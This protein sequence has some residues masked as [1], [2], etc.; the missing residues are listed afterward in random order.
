MYTVSNRPNLDWVTWVFLG[1]VALAGIFYTSFELTPSSYG[2]LLA[3]IG[4][5]EEG[6][7][8]GN[9]R[10][11]RSDEWAMTTPF[12]QAAVRNDFHRFNA[13]SFYKED[14]RGQSIPVALPLKD[15]G[16]VFKPQLW[17]FFLTSPAIAYSAFWALMMCGCL[18]GYQ[19][20][21]RQFGADPLLAVAVSL[22]I[23]CCGFSQFWWTTFAPLIA[24]FPWILLIL[25][26]SLRWWHKALLFSWLMPVWGLADLYPGE[27]VDLAFISLV[28]VLA[29]RPALLRQPR[30]IAAV[31]I[32]ALAMLLVIAA[33]YADVIPAMRDSEYPGHRV[34]EPG[35][36]SAAVALS[37]FFPYLAF[38]LSGYVPIIKSNICELGA[39]GSF[40]PVLNLCLVR[41]RDVWN[42]RFVRRALIILMS[43]LA[44]VT[45]WE[46]APAPHWIGRILQWDTAPATR[47]LLA[48][49]LLI[50]FASVLLWSRNLITV[51]PARIRVF[52]LAGPLAAVLLKLGVYHVSLQASTRD[53][54]VFAFLCVAAV[55]A[56]YVPATVGPAVLIAAIA[57]VNVYAFGRF[58][59]LQPA[60]PIFLTPET[61]I[62]HQLR[63][64]QDA[65]P[66]HILINAN[67]P[68]ATLNGLGV[69]AVSH[70]LM[71][72]MPIFFRQYFPTMDAHQFNQVFNRVSHIQVTDDKLPRAVFMDYLA[73]PHQAFEPVLNL[74]Q[75]TIETVSHKDC[76]IQ[77]GGRIERVTDQGDQVMIDGWAPWTGEDKTQELH[78]SSAR[79]LRAGALLTIKRLDVAETLKDYGFARAG[80][81]LTLSS[82]DGKPLHPDE[83]VLVA[84]NTS[85]GLAQLTG[86][87]CR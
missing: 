34:A 55:V 41:Y 32:G 72:P 6:P 64:A 33:Y 22:M 80:F 12:F 56:S 47:L 85:Q 37:Q 84:R 15:W 75:L 65:A 61:D 26:S 45:F 13:T 71:A 7:V 17:P 9:S 46:T 60:G 74:R 2:E 10:Y 42:D 50:T 28:L 62:T 78:V 29:I 18:A 14:L 5:P 51:T 57:L 16:L 77:R 19:L 53:L 11:I 25:F 21:F 38:T 87:G 8:L 66:D 43:A 67:L 70:T 36:V 1:I 73:V 44:L 48:S 81:R 23:F 69:R 24:G 59:P 35:I 68:G 83:I 20:L 30:E 40:L 49:G 52:V 76:S 63:A 54:E 79:T 86:C 82:A 31:G 3:Q 39:V 4:A 27:I 58:N